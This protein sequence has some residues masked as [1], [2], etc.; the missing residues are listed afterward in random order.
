MSIYGATYDRLNQWEFGHKDVSALHSEINSQNAICKTWERSNSF[1]YF[2]EARIKKEV[3]A[4]KGK[5]GPQK[6][7]HDPNVGYL[8]ET[9]LGGA[10][11]LVI[12]RFSRSNSLISL[13]DYLVFKIQKTENSSWFK[14][15]FQ[16][17]K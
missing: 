6:T 1:Q 13:S 4:Y 15:N 9:R 16:A 7:F 17:F 11:Q 12:P 3:I 8:K 2:I 14:G 5:A 10:L